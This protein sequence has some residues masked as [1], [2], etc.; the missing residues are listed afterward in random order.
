MLG[1][2]LQLFN[3][4]GR[5]LEELVPIEPGR[6]RMYSCGLT[7]YNYAH[8]GNL[9]A[10]LFTDTLRRTLQLKGYDVTQVMNITD[11]G[12]LTSDADEGEDKME[13]A[14]E[15]RGKTVWEIAA[16]YTGEFQRDLGRLNVLEPSI[17]CRATDHVQ[18]MI[19]F[20]R[21]IEANGYAY[22]LDDGLYF[23][24][25][26]VTDYGRLGLVDV[27]GL[28]EGARVGAKAGKR[29]PT[30]FAVWRRSPSDRQRL[31]EWHSPWGTGAPGWHLECS[32]MGIKYLGA[33]FDVH[34]GG[35]DHRQVHHPNEM[36][37]NEAFLGKGRR[38]VNY[39]LHNEFLTFGEEGEKMS[40]STGRF[41]RLATL[42]GWGIH[43]LAFRHFVLM[44]TYRRPLELSFE[45]LVSAQSGLVR[46][47]RRV[48]A[49]KERVGDL[50]WIGLAGEHR[51][52]RGGSFGYLVGEL[53]EPVGDAAGPWL[54]RLDEALSRDLGTPTVLAHLGDLLA[55]ESL[56]PEAALRL[57]AVYDL[58][59]GLDLLT[60]TPGDLNLRPESAP[61]TAEE[62]D[63]LLEEREAARRERDFARAD[64]IRD[65]LTAGGVALHDSRDGT[66]WEWQPRPDEPAGAP[67]AAGR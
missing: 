47:L 60:L 8:I 15:R 21:R 53:V 5:E 49:L 34:T 44:A 66:A 30:D 36:A 29:N 43:P 28:R 65:R 64:E 22:P 9:R 32:V 41:L 37:Q 3:S 56:A 16:Y 7:V 45:A 27:E 61:F 2:P 1:R 35:I 11:V 46:T 59:L 57:A 42:V 6:V 40:K 54:D 20:A 14:A 52:S 12:H 50:D 25:S 10:Y 39:W 62:V 55:D 31:M 26:K 33:P 51:F 48:A 67:A 38:A 24:T 63:A 23:D 17:W 58:A 18:E 19:D 4:L 13:L